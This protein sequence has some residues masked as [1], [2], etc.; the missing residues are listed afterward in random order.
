MKVL[1]LIRLLP[2]AVGEISDQAAKLL[3]VTEGS[4][5]LGSTKMVAGNHVGD[6]SAAIQKYRGKPRVACHPRIHRSRC[7]AADARRPA[8]AQLWHAGRGMLL[9]S[10]MT[11]AL[12]PMVLIGITAY[13]GAARRVDS[14]IA[15]MAR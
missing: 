13:P 4:C 10:G 14:G 15:Q 1:W 7:R 11:I 12:E 8:G 9:R 2:L 3:E 6:I 5:T